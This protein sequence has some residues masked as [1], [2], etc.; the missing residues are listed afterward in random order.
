[1]GEKPSPFPQ[2]GISAT[3]IG[4][5]VRFAPTS[6]DFSL[7]IV[8]GYVTKGQGGKGLSAP[9]CACPHADRYIAQAGTKKK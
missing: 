7:L 1:M 2:S 4:G 9:A 8:S 5:R 3:K 6:E